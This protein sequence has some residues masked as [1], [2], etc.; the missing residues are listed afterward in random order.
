MCAIPEATVARVL[1]TCLGVRAG[2][3]VA[4]LR[5]PGTDAAVLTALAAGLEARRAVP[6]LVEVPAFAVPGTEP[7]AAVAEALLAADAGIELTSAFIGSSRARQAA[8][9]AGR[10]YLA[11]PAVE[12]GTFRL[13][14]PLDVDFD[15][16]VATTLAL[17]RAWEEAEEYRI[18]TPGG[19][20]LRGSVA[21]RKG[22]ALTGV[23]RNPGDYMA[24]P[25]V[26]SG[27]AP[28]EGSSN[29][30]VVIDGDFLF[31]GRGPVSSPVELEIR[32]GQLIGLDGVEGERLTEMIAR[33]GDPRMANL[34]EVAVGLNPQ[35]S[36][37]GVP[38]ETESTKGSAHI[39]FG[40]SIAYGGTV[41]AP[42]H[43]DC[44]M[45]DATVYL[46][47]VPRIVGG[48]LVAA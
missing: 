20:D 12:A 44:V 29:G 3:R 11:M 10:R 24:P 27:T 42:A 13:G 37:C 4:L 16:L 34:A 18:T 26:E 43:L 15:G 25:D 5:D 41:A 46:D 28:V 9:A 22:R 47:G 31:M 6:V 1:D 48:E 7:P 45:R 8:T 21:G 2:E 14:G 39:A 33:V 35:G 17:A 23:A 40:N 30:V 32:D 38:M 19:T 36:V